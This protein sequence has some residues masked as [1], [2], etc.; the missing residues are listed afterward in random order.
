[1]INCL[2]LSKNRCRLV[3]RSLGEGGRASHKRTITRLNVFANIFLLGKSSAES[4]GDLAYVRLDLSLSGK[5]LMLACRA[6]IRWSAG[7]IPPAFVALWR[8]SSLS[9]TPPQ[10][11]KATDLWD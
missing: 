6:V 9:S 5:K 3:R 7:P 1:M 4:K 11:T 2:K 10:A 8:Q